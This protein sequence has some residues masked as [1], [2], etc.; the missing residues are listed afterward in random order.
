MGN[1]PAEMTRFIGRRHFA[2]F[3]RLAARAGQRSFSGDQTE[4]IIRLQ[5]DSG[6]LRAALEYAAGPAAPTA[7]AIAMVASLTHFWVVGGHFTEGRRW[8]DRVLA[9]HPERIPDR[10]I[11]VCAGSVLATLQGDL[12]AAR[13]LAAEARMLAERADDGRALRYAEGA[14]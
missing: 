1:L 5:R 7:D 2:H 4:W 6:D 8:I 13:P 3:R 9:A 14:A 11:A 10:V 12:D